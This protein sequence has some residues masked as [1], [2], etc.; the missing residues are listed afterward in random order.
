MDFLPRTQCFPVSADSRT[1]S[2]I[3]VDSNTY[4]TKSSHWQSCKLIAFSQIHLYTNF[5]HTEMLRIAAGGRIFCHQNLSRFFWYFLSCFF[6]LVSFTCV[7]N[8]NPS[9]TAGTPRGEDRWKQQAAIQLIKPNSIGLTDV[10]APWDNENFT[11]TDFNS[12][13]ASEAYI[14]TSRTENTD[15][16]TLRTKDWIIQQTSAI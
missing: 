3:T 6:F 9:L 7:S 16:G 2:I 11:G 4:I 1:S 14:N 12:H 15:T 8:Y 5:Y 13:S 10:S